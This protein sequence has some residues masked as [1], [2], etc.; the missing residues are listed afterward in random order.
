MAFADEP[1]APA[2]GR[3]VLFHHGDMQP[4]P[5][6]VGRCGDAGDAGPDD[7]DRPAGHGR[8]ARV[9]ATGIAGRRSE[10]GRTNDETR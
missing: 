4:G 3:S 7:D 2:A 9:A 8:S 5:G 6:E 1:A 10:R